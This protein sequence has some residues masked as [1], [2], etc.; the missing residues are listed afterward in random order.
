MS[1][2]GREELLNNM[3]EVER[4]RQKR[5]N[6]H[7]YGLPTGIPIVS[8]MDKGSLLAHTIIYINYLQTK[9]KDLKLEKRRLQLEIN[10]PQRNSTIG[11][12]GDK[13][14][15]SCK[16]QEGDMGHNVEHCSYQ[17]L[18]QPSGSFQAVTKEN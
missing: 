12:K 4:Q 18:K 8:K 3:E 6:Q 9:A 5:L 14:F 1:A 11:E 17:R 10:K 16:Q 2:N 7:F 15:Y 13:E